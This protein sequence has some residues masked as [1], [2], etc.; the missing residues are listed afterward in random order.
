M[1]EHARRPPEWECRNGTTVRY[2]DR[3]I[4]TVN[5]IEYHQ[6]ELTELNGRTREVW[7]GRRDVVKDV[8]HHHIHDG[9]MES[10]LRLDDPTAALLTPPVEY[11]TEEAAVQAAK[12]E[13]DGLDQG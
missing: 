8:W 2:Q 1:D 13:I 4:T 7:T 5:W 10:L 11:P 3:F 12:G 9:T 6:F